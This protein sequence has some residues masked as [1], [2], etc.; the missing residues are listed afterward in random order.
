MLQVLQQLQLAV[1]S[2]GE[3]RCA[4]WL[5]DLLDGYALAG[6][7]IFGGAGGLASANAVWTQCL[8]ER[9]RT[10]QDQMH[11]SRPDGGQR[12]YGTYQFSPGQYTGNL[13]SARAPDTWL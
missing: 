5:H 9:L 13:I 8:S 12:I 1:C 7:Y 6:K 2:L 11:P 4:K 10:R 3:D